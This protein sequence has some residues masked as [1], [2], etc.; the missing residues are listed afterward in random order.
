MYALY[1][2]LGSELMSLVW[3]CIWNMIGW[4]VEYWHEIGMHDKSMVGWWDMA[5][6]WVGRNYMN[7]LVRSRG[8]TLWDGRNSM[9]FLVR[10]HGCA[11]CNGCNSMNLLV[12]FRG[13]ASAYIIR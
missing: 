6:V 1:D 12:R 5:M 9:N 11:S 4:L 3:I 8:G 7:L 2:L 10:A 13:G